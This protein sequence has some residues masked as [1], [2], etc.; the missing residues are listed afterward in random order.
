MKVNPLNLESQNQAKNTLWVSWFTQ[1]KF[2]Q[3]S[4]GVAKLWS[5]KHP[6]RD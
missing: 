6:N 1:E 4:S 5:D 2:E 3:I